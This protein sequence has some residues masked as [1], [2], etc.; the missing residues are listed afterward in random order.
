MVVLASWAVVAVR[1]ARV[2]VLAMK[3]AHARRV[4]GTVV[5]IQPRR[6]VL[7][8]VSGALTILASI[9]EEARRGRCH[10]V[11]V[12]TI[13][14]RKTHGGTGS[15]RAGAICVCAH[16][17]RAHR[18]GLAGGD[19]EPIDIGET[20]CARCAC[21]RATLKPPCVRAVFDLTGSLVSISRRCRA[22][23]GIACFS[24]E[25]VASVSAFSGGC[26]RLVV[27]A[28]CRA[29]GGVISAGVQIAGRLSAR[30]C[31]CAGFDEQY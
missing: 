6:A 4:A 24:T 16:S 14:A 11:V 21:G 26:R 27:N 28:A 3:A 19:R 12:G 22:V 9:T 31:A 5:V 13:T 15:N 20:F 7:T 18:A 30:R 10:I 23:R 8:D 2:G 25:C 29:S 1:L 17:R